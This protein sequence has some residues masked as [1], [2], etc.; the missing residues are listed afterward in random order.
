M[1]KFLIFF[2]SVTSLEI[3]NAQSTEI[4]GSIILP[5]SP[6]PASLI[7]QGKE[8]VSMYTG[9]LSFSIPV[10]NL[11]S[12][13]LSLPINLSY[14]GSGIKVNDIGSW[15]GLGWSLNAGGVVSRVMR[16]LPDEYDGNMDLKGRTRPAKGWLNPEVRGNTTLD[17]LDYYSSTNANGRANVIE[18][19]N[20]TGDYVYGGANPK[21]WDTEPDE[22]FF[23]FGGYSGKFIFDKDGN[24]QIIPA[25][26][27]KISRVITPQ[28]T[29]GSPARSREITSFEITTS[30]GVVYTFGNINATTLSSL[31]AVERTTHH[32][33]TQN[34]LLGRLRKAGSA[35]FPNPEIWPPTGPE[36][37]RIY[38]WT[39]VAIK[40]I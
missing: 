9:T 13:S 33:F 40:N 36:Q 34:V 8:S 17:L 39:L 10:Y 1:R 37:F 25:Q 29:L 6:T 19:S 3:C 5:P 38:K 23:S 32:Y 24:I 16:G 21:A 7:N 35:Q 27:L 18:F 31:T 14:T 4:G 30:E 11:K 12:R 20:K 28:S 2:L 22:F 15:V 26:N